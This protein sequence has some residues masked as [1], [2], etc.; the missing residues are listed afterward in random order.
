MNKCLQIIHPNPNCRFRLFC[1][2][3]AGSGASLYAQWGKYLDDDIEL[4]AIQLPGRE[5]RRDECLCRDCKMLVSE[6]CSAI[7]E[8][9]DKPFAI[10]GYSMG[11]ILAYELTNLI[12]DRY[13]K[14]PCKLFMS[15][16]T[17]F[18]EKRN[19]EISEMDNKELT[20]YMEHSG[21]VPEPVLHDSRFCKE[22]FPIIRNDYAMIEHYRF[23]YRRVPCDIVAFAS[24][25]DREVRFENIR[26][27]R[28]FTR[29][30]ELH[31]MTGSHFFIRQQSADLGR[32]IS[33]TLLAG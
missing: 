13:Q 20:A 18:R 19:V 27:M 11:G 23:N 30:F 7:G 2:P 5:S 15:A 14:T 25:E 17:L 6:I 4:C 10:F 33:D 3:Y 9:L 24:R 16:S 32:I 31:L 8:L 12:Y 1:L 26:L 22:Y 21:G 28:F 29:S